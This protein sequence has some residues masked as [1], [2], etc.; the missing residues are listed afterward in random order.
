MH[1]TRSEM[2]FEA[3]ID[4]A[5]ATSNRFTLVRLLAGKFAISLTSYISK[6]ARIAS[7]ISPSFGMQCKMTSIPNPLIHTFL[8]SEMRAK[9]FVVPKG[10]PSKAISGLEGWRN[11]Q[12]DFLASKTYFWII[13]AA[14]DMEE[15]QHIL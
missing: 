10:K 15:F 4:P 13:A 14:S 11:G 6:Y 8:S 9:R 3:D 5:D 2:W 7:T 12:F 1:P